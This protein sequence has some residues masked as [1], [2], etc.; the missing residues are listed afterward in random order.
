MIRVFSTVLGA[1][2]GELLMFHPSS[3]QQPWGLAL[4]LICF[5][6]ILSPL[7]ATQFKLML[8]LGLMNLNA[9]VLCQYTGCCGSHGTTSYFLGR[10][11]A[12]GGGALLAVVLNRALWPWR[13]DQWASE[14]MVEVLELALSAARA[15]YD[16][17]YQFVSDLTGNSAGSGYG[18]ACGAGRSTE[19]AR[20]DAHRTAIAAVGLAAKRHRVSCELCQDHIV[21]SVPTSQTAGADAV[22]PSVAAAATAALPS[23]PRTNQQQQGAVSDIRQQQQRMQVL[24][25]PVQT[26]VARDTVMQWKWTQLAIPKVRYGL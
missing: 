10:I 25:G 15:L 22:T 9:V 20:G 3:A 17:E 12:T 13:R 14:Q 16:R 21:I 24:L 2:I 4:S 11:L 19:Q 23:S 8:C 26:A 1:C 5:A 18:I 7:A 6:F